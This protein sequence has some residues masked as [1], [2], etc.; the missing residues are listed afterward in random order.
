MSRAGGGAVA[1]K[2]VP[3]CVRLDA[4]CR[5]RARGLSSPRH[6][7]AF[8][9]I[10]ALILCQESFWTTEN[11]RVE[12][13]EDGKRAIVAASTPRREIKML[14]SKSMFRNATI[15]PVN[16]WAIM[17]PATRQAFQCSVG[18]P[19]R[20]VRSWRGAPHG[21]TH[22]GGRQHDEAQRPRRNP[23]PF[24]EPG[25]TSLRRR[26]NWFKVHPVRASRLRER[27]RERRRDGSRSMHRRIATLNTGSFPSA[28]ALDYSGA[29]RRYQE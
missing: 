27:L 20:Q 17:C 29:S 2:R 11:L 3:A 19:N 24:R 13:T 15:E 16:L 26:R 7:D 12:L 4:D 21:Q 25:L 1:A 23:H 18:S 8:E 28:R 6:M 14:A 10:V 9:D 22:N 5:A